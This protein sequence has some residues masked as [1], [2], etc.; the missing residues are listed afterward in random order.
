MNIFKYENYY[1]DKGYH[2]IVGIDEAGRGPLAGPVV[3]VALNWGKKHIIEGV[4]DSKKISQ[5]KRLTLYR[6]IIENANDIGIGIVHEN[7]IDEINILQSTFLAM[8][9]AVGNLSIKP[10]ILLVDGNKADIKHY[11]QKNIIKGDSLSYSI[12]CASII[13]KVT[14]DNLM[15]EFSKVFPEYNF[16]KHK[17]YGTKFH[18][19]MIEKYKSTPIHRK[20]FNPVSKF[21]P[22][23][24]D[25]NT[26]EKITGLGIKICSVHYIKDMY[27]ILDIYDPYDLIVY[28]NQKII[29]NTISVIIKGKTINSK[30]P[31]NSINFNSVI[32]YLNTLVTLD[33]FKQILINKVKVHMNKSGSKISIIK[34]SIYDI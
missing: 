25:F 33:D 32:N 14:R 21:L 4:K 18:L 29:I 22:K 5:K 2:N 12:A 1:L 6:E 3:A 27:K 28:R 17:G 13:A 34:G 8:R 23:V 19:E 10:D 11:E 30:I 9:K 16:D 26:V 20:S 31:L 15:L 7:Q 24:K